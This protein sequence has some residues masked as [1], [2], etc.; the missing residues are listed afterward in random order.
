MHSYADQ[1]ES[2]HDYKTIKHKVYFFFL[3]I[4]NVAAFNYSE[5]IP[6]PTI[7]L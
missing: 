7:R 1:L 4:I 6:V 5:N 2:I 3:Q